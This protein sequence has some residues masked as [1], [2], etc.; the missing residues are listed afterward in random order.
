[1]VSLQECDFCLPKKEKGRGKMDKG[2]RTVVSL[3]ECDFCLAKKEKG[4]GR[5]VG[6]EQLQ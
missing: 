1:M 2:E 3:H 6:G 4:R 5:K